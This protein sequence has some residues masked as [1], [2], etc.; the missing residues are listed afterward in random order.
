MSVLVFVVHMQPNNIGGRR[1]EQTYYSIE[2]TF[3]GEPLT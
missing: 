3:Y 1:C 2:F